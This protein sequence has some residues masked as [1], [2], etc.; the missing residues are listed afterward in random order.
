MGVVAQNLDHAAVGDTPARAVINHAP[1]F[2]L[3]RLH[4]GNPPLDRIQLRA[5][6]RI[7]LGTGLVGAVRKTQKV[8]DRLKREAKVAGVADKG[9]AIL[10]RARVK[11][12]VPGG[13]LG[14]GKKADLLVIADR[15]NLHS[16]GR[17][18]FS[19]GQY[20]NPLDL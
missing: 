10:R 2:Q 17:A 7:D 19:D 15:G 12:L 11:A 18:K 4:P 16:G 9:K 6:D 13:A 1:K 20:E 8:A 14:R 5:R 3:Q